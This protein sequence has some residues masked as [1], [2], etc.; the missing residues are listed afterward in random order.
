VTR[1]RRRLRREIDCP[2]RLSPA[3]QVRCLSQRS[4]FTSIRSFRDA[5]TALQDTVGVCATTESWNWVR[6]AWPIPQIPAIETFGLLTR[7][8]RL[9]WTNDILPSH[10]TP[11][12]DIIRPLYFTSSQIRVVKHHGCICR[13]DSTPA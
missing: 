11:F 9:Y 10:P 1:E 3:D 6:R 2:G 5:G 4:T 8:F 12:R 7:D 13:T